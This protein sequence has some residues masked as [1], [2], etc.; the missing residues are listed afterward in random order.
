[1]DL[2]GIWRLAGF[3]PGEG[4]HQRA[5]ATDFDDSRWLAARVPGNVH[6]AL[7]EAG[8]IEPPFYHLNI[9]ACQWI[10]EREWWYR[11]VCEPEA[12]DAA[13]ARHWLVFDGLDT[14]CTTY[15]NGEELGRHENMFIQARYDVTGNLQRGR[16]LIAL[17]FDPISAHVGERRVTGQWTKRAP[18]RAW[19][20]K[21]QY[22]FGWDWGPRLLTAGPWRGVRL[23]TFHRGR[24]AGV[25][26]W[27]HFIAAD[28]DR[29][30]AAVEVEIEG[31]NDSPMGGGAT[32]E[33]A[34]NP[35]LG[36][37]VEISLTRGLQRQQVVTDIHDHGRASAA[38]SIPSPD[39]WWTHDLGTP[40]LYDL[41]VILRSSDQVLDTHR[42]QVGLRTITWDQSPDPGEPGTRFFTPV[43]NG[44]R[45][46][47][48]G[49]NWIPADSFLPEVDEA[50]CRDLLDLAAEAH[51]NMLRVWGGGVYEAEF[52][53]RLCDELGILVWQ[54]F[55]YACARYPDYEPSF[56]AEAEREARAAVGRLRNHACIAVWC[57]NNEN[58]W[59]DDLRGW[60]EPGR[61]FPGQR[62]G[63]ELLPRV[64]AEMD[65]TRFYW[66][67]SPY[68]GNDHNDAAEGDRHNWQVWHGSVYP[69]RFGQKP[70]ERFT[71]EGVSYRH[72]A[73]DLARF[74]SEF[75]MHASP[76]METLRRNIPEDML[77]AGSEALLYRNK[78]NPKDKGN[79]LMRA[80][81]GL[82]ANLD[83]YVDFSMIAQAEGLKFGVEHYRR[84]KPHCSGTLLWQLNDCWPGLSWSILDYYRFP[85][86]GYFYVKR[87]FAPV[88]A[89]F[90]PVKEG[91]D[92][93]IVNDTLA[94]YDDDLRWGHGRFDGQSL[95]EEGLPISVPPNSAQLVK[96]IG[97]VDLWASPPT[98][99][100][101]VHSGHAGFPS[102][103][104]FLAEI[105]DLRRPAPRFLAEKRAVSEQEVEV[106]FSSDQFVYYVK[107]ECPV[108]GIRYS[109]NYFD[110]F[111]ASR[112][113][114][115]VRSVSGRPITPD[116]I[117]IAGLPA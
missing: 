18:E 21:A 25:F 15:L 22:H 85:K 114:A 71:A 113:A 9:E 44:L 24:I 101:Y 99:Y 58:D 50:R 34:A 80:H 89:T 53:Y 43:L 29:A 104:S 2:S 52:F 1:M 106:Q 57:G 67:S 73:E 62:I 28:G 40:A 84:R 7:V 38:L 26:F 82:P 42:E 8:Q 33:L 87:A 61:D 77:Y 48:K 103:R 117:T 93:W 47:A 81:T 79:H 55:M 95:Y 11:T 72:Y 56:F 17:R 92:L 51:M 36:L 68:G 112:V 27:T 83:Q 75:G 110:L 46:F 109:D 10:E 74:V 32:S 105:K 97:R 30:E 66:P 35:Y 39:L 23:E 86:A 94:E 45:I 116:D 100:L 88:I 78:D 111:P 19:V 13:H 6:T 98:D 108:D 3:H 12:D 20:R 5:F 70:E 4:Q 107:M 96:R 60:Q 16:N 31:W 37:E 54:D 59:L 69:R 65:T 91:F 76:V 115:R 102:N 63:H 41:E 64:L 90:K 14:L 49:A